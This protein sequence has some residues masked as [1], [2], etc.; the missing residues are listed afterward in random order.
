MHT[1][2]SKQK[3]LLILFLANGFLLFAQSKRDTITISNYIVKQGNIYSYTEFHAGISDPSNCIN[4]TT[5]EDSAFSVSDGI[6]KSFF[7]VYQNDYVMIESKDAWFTYGNIDISGLKK[8]DTIKIG[9]F[10]GLISKSN[11]HKR[12][13]FFSLCVKNDGMRM[14]CL[15]YIDLFDHLKR[16]NK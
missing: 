3:F 8:M 13:I 4:I 15:H 11:D 14:S 1:S 2:F 9:Q 12:E 5:T 7:K 6:V 10:L 16:Y